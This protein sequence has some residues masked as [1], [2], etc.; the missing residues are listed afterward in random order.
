VTPA[1]RTWREIRLE[2]N[3]RRQLQLEADLLML[4]TAEA[5]LVWALQPW[6]KR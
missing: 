6:G 4:R 2:K 3:R 1:L 5:F